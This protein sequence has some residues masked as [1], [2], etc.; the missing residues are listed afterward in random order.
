MSID[1]EQIAKTLEKQVLDN[2]IDSTQAKQMLE[3]YDYAKL[4]ANT[5]TYD[6]LISIIEKSDPD[7]KQKLL[8]VL[9]N[10]K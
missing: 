3:N 5:L 4:L 7:K 1:K 6:E 10:L 8:T 2:T 9:K